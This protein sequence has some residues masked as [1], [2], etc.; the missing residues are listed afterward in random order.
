MRPPVSH[1]NS[2]YGES[3]NAAITMN[4]GPMSSAGITK[5]GIALTEANEEGHGQ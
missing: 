2:R 5:L 4:A 1:S 3:V